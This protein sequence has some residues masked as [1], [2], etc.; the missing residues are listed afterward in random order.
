MI[1]AR[2][3]WDRNVNKAKTLYRLRN[4]KTTDVVSIAKKHST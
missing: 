2:C 4:T 1:S 3:A